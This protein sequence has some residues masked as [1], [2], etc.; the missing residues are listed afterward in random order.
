VAKK[1][2]RALVPTGIV[3]L[4]VISGVNYFLAPVDSTAAS[5]G[6]GTGVQQNSVFPQS[7]KDTVRAVY[8]YI[9]ANNPDLACALFLPSGAQAFATDLGGTSC[10]TAAAKVTNT[11]G[12]NAMVI[13]DGSATISGPTATIS[14]CQLTVDGGQR[15]GEFTL[16]K[17]TDG[18][19]AII[20]HKNEP[21]DCATTG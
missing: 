16:S 13:P 11:A 15:L 9:A 4:A 18:G 17:R 5:G 20:G 2:R 6:N 7:P 21:A 14:S 19:W 12:Y 3:I 1:Q 8:H 10:H